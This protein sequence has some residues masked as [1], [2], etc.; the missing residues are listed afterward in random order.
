[1]ASERIYI[2]DT[3][4]RDGEQVPGC[5]LN[6]REKVE[7][8]LQLEIL[9]VDII[10]AGF[11]SQVLVILKQ[12]RRYL[13]LSKKLWYVDLAA[14]LKKILKRL[15]KHSDLQKDPGFIPV[16]VLLISILNQNSTVPAK[17]F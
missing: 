2:F 7:I 16:L 11:P 8:A 13:K 9:G 5:K 6:T 1:M 10:E 3:T 14:L 17:I 12:F 4:L 15:V